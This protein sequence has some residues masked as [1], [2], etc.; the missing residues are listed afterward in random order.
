M[1]KYLETDE[2]VSEISLKVEYYIVMLNYIE[3]I[4]KQLSNRTYQIKNSIDWHRF[5]AGFG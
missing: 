4:L 5:Q 3:S 2:K 1:Q